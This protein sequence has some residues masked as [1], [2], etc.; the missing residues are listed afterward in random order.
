[1]GNISYGDL[2]ASIGSQKQPASSGTKPALL[3]GDAPI[4]LEKSDA[5]SSRNPSRLAS[6]NVPEKIDDCDNSST[7]T[8]SF[9]TEDTSRKPNRLSRN[10]HGRSSRGPSR[11]STA[12]MSEVSQWTE[13]NPFEDSGS[14]EGP[15][16]KELPQENN[17]A[18]DIGEFNSS[19]ASLDNDSFNL[20]LM[21]SMTGGDDVS[22]SLLSLEISGKTELRIGRGA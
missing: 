19:G 6:Q 16:K 2:L 10:S 3:S 11:I 18:V 22:E 4:E 21:S 17:K 14:S 13:S 8:P 1:M 7:V 5:T 12:I 9:S 20:S 15:E